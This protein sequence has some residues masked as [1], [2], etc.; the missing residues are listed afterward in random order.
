M[1]YIPD[2]KIYTGIR[3]A[4]LQAYDNK[5][6]D[7]FTLIYRIW[8]IPDFPMH[9]PEHHVLV[10]AVLLAVYRVQKGDPR[11][12]LEKDLDLADERG[13]NILPGFCGFHGACGAGVGSGIFLSILTDTTPLSVR[14]WGLSNRLTG[15]CLGAIGEK[16]GPRCCKR[17]SLTALE[18]TLPFM[19]ENLNLNIPSAASIQ[20]SWHEDNRECLKKACS[21][22]PD[23]MPGSA[24]TSEAGGPG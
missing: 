11:E 7:P 13:R 12:V 3:E 21:Y 23:N 9:C 18:E 14:T 5:I 17:V 6:T 20:C 8:D 22:Y 10:P 19:R 1:A 4:C 15:L 16:G 2:E 24:S